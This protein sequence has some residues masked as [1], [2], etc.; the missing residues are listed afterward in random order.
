ML[1]HAIDGG[2]AADGGLV[3]EVDPPVFVSDFTEAF[4]LTEN[5]A[6]IYATEGGTT[7]M[8]AYNV[9]GNGRPR[10]LNRSPF[11]GD[12][13]TVTMLERVNART[14]YTVGR[15]T[16]RIGVLAGTPW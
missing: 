13:D 15:G 16:Q 2:I 9:R 7:H 4:L 11:E 6:R 1:R 14:L 10:T 12:Y 8:H 3:A 5:D